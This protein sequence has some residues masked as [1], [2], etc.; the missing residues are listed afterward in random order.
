MLALSAVN[1]SRAAESEQ[2]TW[3]DGIYTYDNSP[4]LEGYFVPRRVFNYEAPLETVLTNSRP[5]TPAELSGYENGDEPQPTGDYPLFVFKNHG[6]NVFL[7]QGKNGPVD[8][9]VWLGKHWESPGSGLSYGANEPVEYVFQQLPEHERCF[10][11]ILQRSAREQNWVHTDR[12]SYGAFPSVETIV[13][14]WM[15]TA[16]IVVNCPYGQA[17]LAGELMDCLAGQITVPEFR[18]LPGAEKIRPDAFVCI[19]FI[20]GERKIGPA[21]IEGRFQGNYGQLFGAAEPWLPQADRIWRYVSHRWQ[22]ARLAAE[23]P[24]KNSSCRLRLANPQVARGEWAIL[25]L[26]VGADEPGM[27]YWMSMSRSGR[28]GGDPLVGFEIEAN[29][30]KAELVPAGRFGQTSLQATT[31]EANEALGIDYHFIE[32]GQGVLKLA[33]R[34]KRY[35]WEGTVRAQYNVNLRWQFPAQT[36]SSIDYSDTVEVR[37]K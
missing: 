29:E 25:E 27:L 33:L 21:F 12:I 20:G 5:M 4:P 9:R 6:M 34:A 26:V 31:P 2:K 35:P 36:K 23:G 28:D 1:S 3:S 15:E 10:V 24:H 8:F 16:P 22:L 32:C 13:Q 30:A 7:W 17:M 14:K 18:Q 19:T 37:L 11:M